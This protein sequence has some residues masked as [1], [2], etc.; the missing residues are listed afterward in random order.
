MRLH[1]QEA[2]ALARE[3]S[4][5]WNEDGQPGGAI[6]LF[7]AERIHSACA[8][9][10]ADLAQQ[11]LFTPDTV[12]RYAS[13]TKHL[14]AAMATGPAAQALR[15]DDPLARHL[16]ML[17]GANG[18]VTVEHALS[19]LGGLPD[20]RE[21]FS[22]LGLSVYNATAAADILAFLA[23][24]GEL[25]SPPG[26]E[27]SYSNTGYRLVEEALKTQGIR[28]ADLL[29]RHVNIPLG[30][31]FAAPETWF[32]IVPGLTP[33]Y[34][35]GPDGWQ[36][37]C[38][39]LHLS[40]S[41]CVAGSVR[42]LAVW[43]QSLL[44]DRGPGA[45]VLSRIAAPRRLNDGRA[46]GYGLGLAHSR[47]G[48]ARL[49]GHGGSHAGYKTYF[50]LDPV[51]RAGMA[52]VANR[53]DVGT[54]DIALRVTARLL[55]QPLPRQGHAL[56]P[57]LYVAEQGGDWLEVTAGS[58]CWLGA[59]ETLYRGAT[60]AEAVSL[61]SHLPMRLWQ[62]GAGIVGEI[63]HVSRRFLPAQA[64]G[65]LTLLQGGWRLPESRSELVIEGDRLMMGIGPAAIA[66]RLEPLGQGRARAIAQ[67]GPSEK[68]FAVHLEDGR[69]RLQLNRSRGVYYQRDPLPPQAE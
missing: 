50:L 36:L 53:E 16:P 42:E 65:S 30:T 58:A 52:V 38:A 63:G 29:H 67:D 15:L 11:T 24:R 51:R 35:P 44:S 46:T 12:V 2:E 4:Q 9:G 10:L 69:L 33:G 60:P 8:G 23:R 68:R 37:A 48:E 54:Y 55:G 62:E 49:I 7:D 61:S 28:F 32:D 66:A 34:W 41:G 14:F 59:T 19:M 21:T 5:G 22:L 1:W 13:V 43:L 25:N 31:R 18:Q 56:T 27:I 39:G 47:L 64:D 45:G 17:T 57:G 3:A 20:V 40:A 26:D 6:V